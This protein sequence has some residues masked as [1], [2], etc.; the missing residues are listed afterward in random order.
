MIFYASTGRVLYE[1]TIYEYLTN[2]FKAFAD[3]VIPRSPELTQQY[4]RVQ[5]YGALDLYTG[6]FII[7]SLDSLVVP[8]ALPVAETL[9]I[10]AEQLLYREGEE[11]KQKRRPRVLLPF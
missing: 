4:G 10:A 7:L 1:K 11:G 3:A 5:Y 8:L 6:E 9:N 2:T